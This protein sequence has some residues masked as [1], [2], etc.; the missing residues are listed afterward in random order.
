MQQDTQQDIQQNTAEDANNLVKLE[1][2]DDKMQAFVTINM[3]EEEDVLITQEE[4]LGVLTNAGVIFQVNQE[5]ISELVE[6]Q[7][8][9]Q[10]I[11]VAEGQPPVPGEDAQI[12]FSF[13]TEKS[14]KPKIFEDG[15]VNYREVSVVHSVEQDAILVRKTPATLGAKGVNVLGEEVAALYGKD[16]EIISEDGTYRDMADPEVIRAAHDGVIFYN[17]RNNT[18]QVQDLYVISK[19]VDFSTGNLNVKSSVEVRGDIKP[20]FAIETPYNVDVRGV[21]EHA[22]IVCGGTLSVHAGITGDGK[23]VTRVDGDIHAGYIHS[24]TVRCESSVYV[25]NEIRNARIDCK[26]EVVVTREN[27]VI[28][29]G[30][31]TARNRISAPYLG[32]V[33]GIP[34]IIEVGVNPDYREPLFKKVAEKAVVE[35]E[36]DKVRQKATDIVQRSQ[37]GAKDFRL[38]RLKREWQKLSTKLEKLTAETAELEQVYYNAPTPEV[39]VSR[40]VYPATIIRIKHASLKV[41]QEISHVRFR[42]VGNDIDASPLVK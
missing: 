15:R 5:A 24:Q 31:T 40:T 37:M 36:L 11:L 20:G 29:G 23:S 21:V 34:T 13:P 8:Y 9:N 39:H 18:V 28:I 35:E 7:R 1:V 12:E 17:S 42:L 2:T 32:S 41:K 30:Q 33:N 27:G 26:D 38:N 22:T 10:R 4:V 19:S 14:L 3:P 25:T 6:E 16:I